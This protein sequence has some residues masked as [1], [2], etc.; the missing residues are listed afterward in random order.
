MPQSAPPPGQRP[1]PSLVHYIA[2]ALLSLVVITGL[3]VL[4]IWLA[5]HPR[6]LRYSIEHGSITGFNLSND[7]LNSNFDFVLRADNPNRRIS[8]YYDKID[9][10]VLYEDQKLSI[11]N[12]HPFYQPRR[13]V[14]FVHLDLVAKNA[15]IYESTARDLKMERAG[16]DLSLDVKIRAKIRLKV[17]LFKIHRTLKVDCESLSVPFDS[18]Q[19]FKSFPCDTDID[20]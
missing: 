12:V 19:P 3:V 7:R 13:N 1:R 16:G 8:L 4:I 17:G 9:V 14:T 2:I 15:T 11:N 18:H 10:T 5:V 20:N 6:K